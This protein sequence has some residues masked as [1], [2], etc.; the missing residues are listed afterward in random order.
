VWLKVSE[1]CIYTV[2]LRTPNVG[3]AKD[4]LIETGEGRDTVYR[5]M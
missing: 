3:T 5:Y 1:S 2:Q 4:M